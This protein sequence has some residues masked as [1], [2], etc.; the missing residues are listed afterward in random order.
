MFFQTVRIN[1]SLK[2]PSTSRSFSGKGVV[3]SMADSSTFVIRMASGAITVKV[4]TDSLVPGET[5]VVSTSDGAVVIE[6]QASSPTDIPDLLELNH[7]Q[8]IDELVSVLKDIR[9]YLI[10][11]V[12]DED[13]VRMLD[14]IILYFEKKDID[15]ASL[16]LIMNDL[17]NVIVPKL[18]DISS[19]ISDSIVERLVDSVFALSKN[20]DTLLT[21]LKS[22]S[23]IALSQ[24]VSVETSSKPGIYHVEDGKAAIEFLKEN[25]ARILPEK[26]IQLENTRES[27]L[28]IKFF[29]VSGE[30]K[31]AIVMPVSQTIVEIEHM[32]RSDVTSR[33]LQNLNPKIIVETIMQR[34]ALTNE[35]LQNID[36]LL[37]P[38][39]VGNSDTLI[40]NGA[41]KIVWPQLVS[42]V[43]NSELKEL[44]DVKNTITVFG[45]QMKEMATKISDY[46]MH[47]HKDK[48]FPDI[49]KIITEKLDLHA[50]KN[51]AQTLQSLFNSVGFSLE[52][53]LSNTAST[54]NFSMQKES[55]SLKLALLFI[56]G[57][58]NANEDD[59]S[60]LQ[61][62]TG[63][64][65]GLEN[66]TQTKEMQTEL[67]STRKQTGNNRVSLPAEEI[68]SIKLSTGNIKQQIEAF[69]G[70]IESLQILAKP[71]STAQGEQQVLVL[72]VHHNDEL[73]EVRV[74]F[75]KE[76][77]KK[78][79]SNS[80]ELISAMVN[81]DLSGLGEVTAHLEYFVKKSM[82]LS[83]MFE[84][85]LAKKWF[86]SHVSD[87]T[88]SLIKCG[89][90][91]VHI[92]LFD[93]HESETDSFNEKR[94]DSVTLSNFNAIG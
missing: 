89:L 21:P 72:P 92:S 46:L 79:G 51:K 5:V 94:Q 3:E 4:P 83:L 49:M 50:K 60:I 15:L 67:T 7:G 77:K 32:M 53:N 8:K 10:K 90:P 22:L 58:L 57:Y 65:N 12:S 47:N 43:L 6:K 13:L 1:A 84:N 45:T 64:K 35:Q 88:E 16:Q 74:R 48:T 28:F 44:M 2:F 34:G 91:A 59:G 25:G 66:T 52:S 55:P 73:T 76:H 18:H 19:A 39:N 75:L 27:P 63:N 70:R 29:E 87:I 82:N 37:R 56:L 85:K 62:G 33:V 20:I 11:N 9:S 17:T 24:S 78:S 31:K 86:Q 68:N 23:E 93:S 40:K 36:S 38:L 61:K 41:M 71:V 26:V 81:V 54:Q 30:S 69:L 14:N 80:P 42:L